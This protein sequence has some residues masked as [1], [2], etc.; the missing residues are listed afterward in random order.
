MIS[1]LTKVGRRRRRRRN[2]VIQSL[3]ISQGNGRGK[4]TRAPRKLF[5]SFLDF[6]MLLF[7]SA[8]IMDPSG[9]IF[10]LLRQTT[11]P[12]N[13]MR[14]VTKS[15]VLLGFNLNPCDRSLLNTL[16]IALKYESLV[17]L[18]IRMLSE[19]NKMSGIPEKTSNKE[20]SW[21]DLLIP[22]PMGNFLYL[23]RPM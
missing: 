22:S 20:E 1:I 13:L 12:Y 19:Y 16:F 10:P 14:S 18:K 3:G 7:R 15:D 11:T 8:A 4:N 6:G 21:I 17:L 9:E 23:K 5:I 2:L